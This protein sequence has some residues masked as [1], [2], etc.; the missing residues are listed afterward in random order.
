M[1]L[2]VIVLTKNE[3]QQIAG[4]LESLEWAEEIIIVD[5]GSVDKTIAI[6]RKFTDKIF[7]NRE[8][9]F[10]AKRNLGLAE[11]KGE[12]LLYV[13]ADERVSSKLQSEIEAVIEEDSFIAYSIPRKNFYYGNHE[14]PYLEKI[15]R[16]FKKNGLKEWKGK[17]HESPIINGPIGELR[18]PL[19][20]YTHRDLSSMVEKTIEWSKIEAQ[21]RFEVNHPPVVWWRFP[22]VMLSEFYRSYIKQGGWKV[23]TVGVIESVYQ[24]FSIFVTYARLWEIQQQ[25]IQSQD[26]KTKNSS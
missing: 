21:L 6:A 24:S 19:L 12:W 16:L 14:W 18:N 1:K 2:S 20:H 26:A 23:G 9:D 22:R 4:C 3:E 17:L 11:A 8:N 13:D 5:S 15:E 10:S 7:L 25:K